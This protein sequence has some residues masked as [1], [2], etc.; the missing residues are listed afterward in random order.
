MVGPSGRPLDVVDT[1]AL[2][3]VRGSDGATSLVVGDI[4]DNRRTRDEVTL[5]RLAEPSDVRSQQVETARLPLRYPDGATDAESLVATSDGRLLVVTK[6]PLWGDVYEVPRD[7]V[8]RL[9]SGRSTS[10]AVVLTR[11]GRLPVSLATDASGLPDGRVV[12][13]DYGS[14]TLYGWQGDELVAQASV[15]LPKQQQG[16]TIAVEPGGRTALVGSE[17]IAQPLWRVG[18][19][20]AP[21]STPSPK[22]SSSA[23]TPVPQGERSTGSAT[24]SNAVLA[25]GIAG[26]VLLAGLGFAALRGARRRSRRTR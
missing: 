13:R 9:L 20:G 12:V 24:R 8:R 11:V 25:A 4:G 21:S 26:A 22:P 10:R 2:A 6:T 17:G 19:D 18:L 23:R 7:A 15:T 1:E 14:A 3:A 16:E 5:L